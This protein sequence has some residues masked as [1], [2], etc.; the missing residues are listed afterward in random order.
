MR[1]MFERWSDQVVATL[2]A[3]VVLAFVSFGGWCLFKTTTATGETVYCYVELETAGD[4]PIFRLYAF[5][6]WRGDRKIASFLTLEP[7]TKAA[8][9]MG[10]P[11]GHR[12]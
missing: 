10:C 1:T 9:E 3:L 2:T 7:A 4:I 6:E 5:R 8:E 12:R 11:L